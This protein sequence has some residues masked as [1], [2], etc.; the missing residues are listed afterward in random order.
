[1]RAAFVRAMMQAAEND[2]SLF[3]ITADMGYSVL[4][5]FEKVEQKHLL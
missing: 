2:P 4:E 3:L 5:A 1:M